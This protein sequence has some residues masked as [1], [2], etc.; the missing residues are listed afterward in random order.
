MTAIVH[1]Y[2]SRGL[3]I[4][5]ETVQELMEVATGRDDFAVD[6]YTQQTQPRDG[7]Q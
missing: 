1:E 7:D 4:P 6:K 5:F 3:G 2:H